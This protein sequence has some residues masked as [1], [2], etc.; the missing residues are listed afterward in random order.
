M[1]EPGKIYKVKV[2][3]NPG[4][5]GFGRATILERSNSSILFHLK[6]SKEQTKVLPKGTRIWFVNDSPDVTFNGLWSS[7]VTGNQSFE[8]QTVMASSLPK[9]EPLVQRRLSQRVNLDAPV[10]LMSEK[11]EELARDVR[12]RDISRSGIALETAHDVSTAVEPGSNVKLVVETHVGPIAAEARIIRV[13]HNWLANKT[14]MGLEF[15]DLSDDAVKEL[16]K[17]L[18][19]LGGKTRADEAQ[20]LQAVQTAAE[21]SGSRRTYT[22]LSSWLGTD[23][24]GTKHSP[25]VGGADSGSED[26]SAKPD[27]KDSA[28]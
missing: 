12:T 26:S 19:M 3:V 18:V 20:V 7:T 25:F 2:E 14:V 5:I 6:T 10:K 24:G 8:R 16:D 1:F 28:E 13:E 21:N 22:G 23:S 15:T 27:E 9:L 4:E 11:D 17:L